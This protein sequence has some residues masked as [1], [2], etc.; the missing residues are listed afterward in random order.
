MPVALFTYH[1]YGSWLPDRRQGYVVRGQGILATNKPLANY[2]RKAMRQPEMQ[3][4]RRLQALLVER[5]LS[6]CLEESYRP[7]AAAAESTHLHLLASWAES[8]LT[9]KRVNNRIKN[10]LSLHLS[11]S[12]GPV[13]KRWF[14]KGASKQ[15]VGN[16]SHFEHLISTYL[17]S[18]QGVFWSEMIGWRGVE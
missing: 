4:D 3:F 15:Q 7:H 13:G 17:P 9:I 16:R 12:V 5:F 11:K 8:E 14:A 1:A 2:R 10:L 6:V 18:H